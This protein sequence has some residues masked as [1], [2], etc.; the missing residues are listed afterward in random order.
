MAISQRNWA[1]GWRTHP[2]GIHDI[3][4]DGNLALVLASVDQDH[5][6][7]LDKPCEDLGGMDKQHVYVWWSQR[8]CEWQ[9]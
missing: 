5:P 2:V 8:T 4:D 3:D 7:D 6:A 1:T 9:R